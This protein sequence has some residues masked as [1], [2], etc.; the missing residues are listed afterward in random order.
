M[1]VGDH[2]IEQ[3]FVLLSGGHPTLHDMLGLVDS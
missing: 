3:L 2:G 1:L